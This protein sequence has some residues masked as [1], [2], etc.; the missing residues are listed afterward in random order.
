MNLGAR[1]SGL[2]KHELMRLARI[3]RQSVQRHNAQNER[4]RHMAEI[5]R[6]QQISD[7]EMEYDRLRGA[8]VHSGP[9]HRAAAQ[10]LGD[11]QRMLHGA[12][13]A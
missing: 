13:N 3:N 4:V 5:K 11:L 9:L 6:R 12:K 1:Q 10:R 2:S 7:Y 8:M